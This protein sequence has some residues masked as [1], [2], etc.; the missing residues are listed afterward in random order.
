MPLA[1]L[2]FSHGGT[3]HLDQLHECRLSAWPI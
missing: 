1:S 2:V 3:V